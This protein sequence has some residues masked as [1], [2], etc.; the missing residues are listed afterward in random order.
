MYSFMNSVVRF[1]PLPHKSQLTSH[2]AVKKQAKTIIYQDVKDQLLEWHDSLEDLA[3]NL[4]NT[5]AIEH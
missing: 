2:V 4:D 1:A 3:A 5:S